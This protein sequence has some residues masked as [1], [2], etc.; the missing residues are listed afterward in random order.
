MKNIKDGLRFY[1]LNIKDGLILNN[2]RDLNMSVE[3]IKIEMKQRIKNLSLEFF[4]EF[5][6]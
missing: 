6:H 5:F 1:P 3:I 4:I 2:R